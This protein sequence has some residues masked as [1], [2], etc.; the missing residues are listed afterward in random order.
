MFLRIVLSIFIVISSAFAYGQDAGSNPT[1]VSPPQVPQT[2]S[3][4]LIDQAAQYLQ[5]SQESISDRVIILANDVDL[6]FGNQRALDEYYNSS[7][8]VTQKFYANSVAS[9][10]YDIQTN[11]NLSLPNWKDTEQRIQRWWNGEE[12]TDQQ[13][14]KKE[15]KELNPWT[16]NDGIGLRFSRP[17]AYNLNARLSKDFLIGPTV[18]HFYEQLSWDSDNLW[19]EVTSLTNDYALDK[20]LLFRF[21]NE[22]DWNISNLQFNSYH[23][24]SLIY[25]IN[26]VSL[27]SFDLRLITATENNNFYTD[28]YTAG[29]TYRTSLHPLDWMFVQITPELSWPRQE[30]FTSVW[31]IYVTLDVVF[32]SR[33]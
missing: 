30:H 18:S 4:P 10:S 26:K 29:I 7:L 23:G 25:T 15:Y 22:A 32:G 27:T 19:Q 8:H 9:G 28:S 33:K 13:V 31:T 21:L 24:P 1:P 17:L 6:L 2:P 5:G 12:S 16:F 11:L 14:S 20:K 3:E